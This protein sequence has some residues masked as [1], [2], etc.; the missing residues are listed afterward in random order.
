MQWAMSNASRTLPIVEQDPTDPEFVNDPYSFYRSIRARGD[1]VFWK[2]YDLAVATTH[3]AVAQT[4]RHPELG[5]AVPQALLQPAQPALAAFEALE[6]HSLLEIEPPAHTRIRREATRA[7]AGPQIVLIAPEI[8]R[9]A[10]RLID[11]F[12]ATRFDLTEAYAKPLAAFTITR[13]LGV[14]TQDA[15]QLQTWSNS[16]VAM[17]QARRDARTEA[18]AEAASQAFTRYMRDLIAVR[19]REPRQDFLSQLIAFEKTGGISEAELLSSA[20]LLLNAGHEATVHAI[21]NAV[22]LLL[23]FEGRSEAL[24]PDSIAGTVEECL[25]YRPPLHLFKRYVYKPT[26]IEGVAFAENEQIGCLLAS[27]NRDDAVWP[28]GVI[29]DP[30]RSRRPHMA[31]GA[32][33]HS[34]IGAALARLELQIALPIL[35][36]RCP[37]LT[38][39]EEP[40][41]ANQYHFHGYERLM[42]A[43]R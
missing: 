8:S 18:A 1:F 36:S 42:V 33:L 34:C 29:F 12:P 20:I 31:F 13:F 15:P 4:L 30:F 39:V 25:R 9:F 17:Y 5:R 27:A 32:G 11:A 35:F 23:A 16:M 6:E 37:T 26:E 41:V 2:D 28:D 14:D 3:K 7:F 24:A 19:R 43:V 22:P 10:D 21:S 38:I 40:K